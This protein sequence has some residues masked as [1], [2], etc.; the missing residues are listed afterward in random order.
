LNQNR[1]LPVNSVDNISGEVAIVEVWRDHYESI[2]N[3]V[4]QSKYKNKVTTTL[5]NTKFDSHMHVSVPEVADTIK[6]LKKGN[7]SS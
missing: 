4:D 6:N 1:L 3:C 5:C 2:L 7:L